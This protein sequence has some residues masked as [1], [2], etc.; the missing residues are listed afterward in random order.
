MTL[1][2]TVR[3]SRRTLLTGAI[4]AVAGAAA[5]TLAGAQA[6]FAAG[7]DGKVLRVGDTYTHAHTKTTLGTS[8]NGGVLELQSNSNSPVLTVLDMKHGSNVYVGSG[9]G[10]FAQSGATIAVLA[11]SG[12]N[13]AIQGASGT[14]AGVYGASDSGNGV[15]GKASGS[16]AAVAAYNGASGPG[17]HGHGASGPGVRADSNSGIGVEGLSSSGSQP[18]IQGWSQAS[19]T[20]LQG[21]SGA[22][23][24]PASPAHAGVFGSAAGAASSVGVEGSSPSGRGGRF[25]GKL[26]QVQLQASAATSH[27]TTG[28]AGD[29][30]VDQGH[31]LWFCKGGTS[32]KQL[33]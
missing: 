29:L 25:K 30:F 4:G 10:V 6:A 3:H 9:P 18:A 32:W 13:H 11:T 17:V 7:D 26:A 14:R 5:A 21:Y 12:S 24:V 19:N 23:P 31:R 20:G 15:Y 22:A 33:A 16:N 28:Q 27:P 8:T 1:D 2:A